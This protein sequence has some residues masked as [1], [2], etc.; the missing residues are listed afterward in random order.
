MIK[1]DGFFIVFGLFAFVF[2]V[3][4]SLAVYEVRL[5]N[6]KLQAEISKVRKFSEHSAVGLYKQNEKQQEDIIALTADLEIKTTRL[7]IVEESLDPANTRWAKIKQVR[8]AVR[9]TLEDFRY[10][11]RMSTTQITT[12]ASAVVDA[13]ERFD[14]PI[15]LVLAMTCRESAFDP[16][17]KSFAGARGLIQIIPSTAREIAGDL[18]IRHYSMFKIRDNVKFGVYYIM[19]MLDE[20]DGD[21]ALAVRAYNC[22]P[23]CVH[24]VL[25]GEWRDYPEETREYAQKILGEEECHSPALSCAPSDALIHYY[26]KMGL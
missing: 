1:A 11:K 12:Y 23:T 24:K 10:R 22:G 19:K 5:N 6:K 2:F 8:E 14:V 18:G 20:F 13:S 25:A 15:S 21:R 3:A 7:S 26:E 4:T 17:A 16:K 9:K